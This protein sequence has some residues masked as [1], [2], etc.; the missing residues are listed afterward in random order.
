MSLALVTKKVK[1]TNYLVPKMK[2][3]MRTDT[4]GAEHSKIQFPAYG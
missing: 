3:K 1:V 4:I 2:E